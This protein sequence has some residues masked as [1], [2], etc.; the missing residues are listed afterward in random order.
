MEVSSIE[1][2]VEDL[3]VMNSKLLLLIGAPDSGKSNLLGEL[4]KRRQLKILNVGAALGQELLT[5]ASPRRNIDAIDLLKSLSDE[6]SQNDLLLMDN[7]EILFDQ[8]L[9]LS[10]LD[11]LKRHSQA[12]CVVAIWPGELKDK[13]LTYAKIGHPEF[14]EYSCDGVVPFRLN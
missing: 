1:R 13:R 6:F 2:V 4:A 10:P 8:E 5:I 3:A 11:I 12:R 9:K 7:L 14:R